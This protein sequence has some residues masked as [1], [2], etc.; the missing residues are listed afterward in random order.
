MRVTVL[1]SGNGGMA[2][3]YDWA[4][5]GHEVRFCGTV[6]FTHTVTDVADAGGITS[7][8]VLEGFAPIKYSGTD[9][10]WAVSHADVVFVAGPAFSIEPLALLAKDNLR[11]GQSIVICPTS[12]VG[13]AVFKR[14]VGQAWDSTDQL[15]GETS[16]LP[17]A[18]RKTGG[19]SIH[20]YNKLNAGLYV[21]G[22]PRSS[23]EPLR[24]L[25][26]EVYPGVETA[27]SI[28]QTTLQNGNPV[29]HP[30]VTLLNA[31]L[32]ERTHGG[33]EFYS[34]GVTPAVGRLMRAV[35]RERMAIA[36][37]L[38]LPLEAEPDIGV[39]QNYMT[40]ANYTTGYSMAPGFAGI[41]AQDQL[42]NRYLTEDVGYTLVFWADLAEKVGV[43]TPVIDTIITMASIVMGRDF[44]G[45]AARTLASVGL[46]TLTAE[47]LKEL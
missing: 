23:T 25:L 41:K 1:G 24:Q 14:T 32:I 33:F 5:H 28:L 27:D 43:R 34:D 15:V 37:A 45:E 12:C 7:T 38:G 46:D 22:L 20:V 9:I 39:R 11:K 17:Y 40:E 31:A 19:A 21:A 8:G 10:H 30:A 18:V 2:I 35:D 26:S 29:I 13:S 6:E 16:T 47:Q 42:D 4:A 3:A 44:R 36:A